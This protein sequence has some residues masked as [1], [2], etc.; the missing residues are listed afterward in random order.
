MAKLPRG[1]GN[2]GTIIDIIKIW[3]TAFLVFCRQFEDAVIQN[4]WAFREK[5]M[6]L[7]AESH[8]PAAE[9]CGGPLRIPPV[10]GDL[11]IAIQS[12]DSTEWGAT[13][14][15]CSSRR[16]VGGLPMQ[17]SAKWETRNWSNTL[18]YASIGQS[19][20]SSR[21]RRRPPDHQ[22]GWEK[23]RDPQW[24]HVSHQP[25]TEGT[26]ITSEVAV[27]RYLTRRPSKSRLEKE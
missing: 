25:R 3:G 8:T 7:L 12:Q 16:A 10:G 4:K 5:A 9:T 27:D 18:S 23:W 20:T 6:Y 13:A 24:E 21:L 1:G 26:P 2:A 17:S 15:I 19:N 22:R 14:R 11:P